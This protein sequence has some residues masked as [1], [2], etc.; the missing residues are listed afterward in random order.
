VQEQFSLDVSIM[1][2][3]QLYGEVLRRG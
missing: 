3:E 2:M 1:Q